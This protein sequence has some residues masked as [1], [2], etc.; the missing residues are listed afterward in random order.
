MA[1][2]RFKEYFAEKIWEMIPAVHRHEDGLAENIGVLRALVEV[3]AE[4]AARVRRSHDRLWEDQFIELCNSWAVPYIG[5]L[6]GTRM[7]SALNLNTRARRVDVAKTIY[8]RR[9][10]GTLSVL[11][12]LISDITGWEGNVV[13]GF[14]R[15]AKTR[16]GLDPEPSYY[17][18]RFTGTLP[19]GFADLRS[20]HA[21]E[22]S[23]SAFD[24]F[25][26][27]PDLR[28]PK[29]EDGLYGIQR[30]L[31][32][33]YR[34]RAFQVSGVIPREVEGTGGRGFTFDPSGRDIPLYMPRN[35]PHHP[36]ASA[37]G[38]SD[39]GKW[40]PS[41]EWELP[42]PIRCRLLGHAEYII[43]DKDI[44]ELVEDGILANALAE[45]L[46]QLSDIHYKTEQRLHDALGQFPSS[47]T[48]L[49]PSKYLP[50][51]SAA[52]IKKCGKRA[53]YPNGVY[54]AENGN[55]ISAEQLTAGDLTSMQTTVADKRIQID[56]ERGRLLFIGNPPV[57]V[58]TT[59][60]VGFAAEIGAGSYDRS[61]VEQ[62][63]ADKQHSGG[64][65]ITAANLLNDGVTQ[66][67]DSASYGPI[68][69]KISV[70][71]MVFIAANQLRP[72]IRL[73]G[74]WVLDTGA[75]EDSELVL[76][77][78]WVG[79]EMASSVVLRGD[80]E[81]VTLR[82]V[83]FDPGGTKTQ[84]PGSD[85]LPTI[86]LV[87]E[88]NIEKL[89]VDASII[90]PIQLANEGY[91]EKI[92]IT[93]SVVQSQDETAAA[94]Q[95]PDSELHLKRV[96][97]IGNV[98]AQC[99]WAADSLI[100]GQGSIQNTQCG[101]FRFSAAKIGSRLPRPYR[102][103]WIKKPNLLFSSTR[104]GNPAFMQ[105]SQNAP[106]AIERGAENLSEMGAFNS[107]INPI[108]LDGLR[109]KVDEYMPFGLLPIFIFE[110]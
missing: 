93:D 12:E 96:T 18:G 44:I 91:V 68:G 75:N 64:G 34:L 32:Y 80:Y 24:E 76:D 108:K 95:L 55:T 102:S 1:E 43:E 97:I 84:D 70:K 45:E 9:R 59:Y 69:S 27:T 5:D 28:K 49:D 88:G 74:N 65:E 85:E 100:V 2:D 86:S 109:A 90:G 30:L 60:H 37:N 67:V 106:K 19:G 101:C 15:L 66:I 47:A 11:E 79:A 61:S 89:V 38:Q 8:Y 40:R 16:H 99:L 17:A 21:A 78:L 36:Q 4:Q 29:G 83:T 50:I 42:A 51:L 104:F 105:L 56:P 41:Y 22:M 26:H 48:F 58:A 82:H 63:T 10:K 94:L 31:F 33:I 92:E 53:L 35:R 20:A 46:R 71:K 57:D 39:W 25:F 23:N 72:Y 73:E 77:G 98:H 6:V 110:T 81:V 107:L 54:V 3:V 52:I 7:V 14:R 13:E 103:V 62:Y 87:V